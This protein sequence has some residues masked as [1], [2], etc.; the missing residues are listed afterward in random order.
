MF[1]RVDPAA[2]LIPYHGDW[3]CNFCGSDD[4]LWWD[5]KQTNRGGD[6]VSCEGCLTGGTYQSTDCPYLPDYPWYPDGRFSSP[7]PSPSTRDSDCGLPTAFSKKEEMGFITR[8]LRK[9]KA[10]NR[11]RSPSPIRF[12]HL[13][14]KRIPPHQKCYFCVSSYEQDPPFHQVPM[15]NM[16]QCHTCWTTSLQDQHGPYSDADEE[17]MLNEMVYGSDNE[18]SDPSPP[19]SHW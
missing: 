17:A 12:L 5:K 11:S 3:S 18:F 6:E 7:S 19:I 1:N 13:E 15:T 4:L 14:G 2:K 16:M 10:Q 8:S 9:V